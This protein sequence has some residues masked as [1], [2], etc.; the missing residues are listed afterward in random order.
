MR[1]VIKTECNFCGNREFETMKDRI[2]RNIK[3]TGYMF[4]IMII[5]ANVVF[6]YYMGQ[7]EQLHKFG[8]FVGFFYTYGANGDDIE[9]RELAINLTRGCGTNTYCSALYVYLAMNDFN[10]I[11]SG[12]SGMRTYQPIDTFRNRAG[13]CSNLAYTY[14]SILHQIG[15]EV[16]VKCESDHCW[17]IVQTTK[18]TYIVDLTKPIFEP[19]FVPKIY[20]PISNE[21]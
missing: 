8:S 12:V 18:G 10:Y 1:R 14:A 21:T 19:V 9:L 13:D 7:P 5:I 4:L 11:Y 3:F 16:Y 6:Y 17:N 2:I 20:V 15:I